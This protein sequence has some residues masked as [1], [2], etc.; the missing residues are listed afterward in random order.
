[1]GSDNS[2]VERNP[3]GAL[4]TSGIRLIISAQVNSEVDGLFI[5]TVVFGS[6]NKVHSFL[7]HSISV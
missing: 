2:L 7:S 4:I 6:P 5:T 3:L 1:M